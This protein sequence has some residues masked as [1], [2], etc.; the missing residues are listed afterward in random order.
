MK[1]VDDGEPTFR[2]SL[3]L[4]LQICW[5]SAADW[6]TFSRELPDKTTSSLTLAEVSITTPGNMVT[7]RMIFSPKKLLSIC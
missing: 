4:T 5:I 1:H 6:D 7:R 3:F 2:I